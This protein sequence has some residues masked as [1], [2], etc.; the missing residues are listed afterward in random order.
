MQRWHNREQLIYQV[1]ALQR[2]GLSRRAIARALSISRNTVIRILL[3]HA[4]A[5]QQPHS[6]QD[7]ADA[8]LA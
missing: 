7:K 8:T 1:V 4:E 2:D 5:R 6:L 3:R